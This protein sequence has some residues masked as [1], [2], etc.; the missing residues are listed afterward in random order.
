MSNP[1]LFLEKALSYGLAKQNSYEVW[2]SPPSGGNPET[3]CLMCTSIQT[4]GR[5]FATAELTV[6]NFVEKIPYHDL[7]D[8]IRAEFYCSGDMYEKKIFDGW[9]KMISDSRNGY[10][11]YADKYKTTMG[12]YQIDNGDSSYSMI[13]A[14]AWPVSVSELS[15]AYSSTNSKH[16]FYVDIAYTKAM[17]LEDYISNSSGSGVVDRG[18]YSAVNSAQPLPSAPKDPYKK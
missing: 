10:Y 16:T 12:I 6:H 17:S 4:P 8:N 5:A 9:Q 3:L 11:E 7:F 1:Q 18:R 14:D 2:F 15:N 13:L